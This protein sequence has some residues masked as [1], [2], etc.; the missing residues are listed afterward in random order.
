MK[1]F[2]VD[3]TKYSLMKINHAS[4]GPTHNVALKLN[5]IFIVARIVYTIPGFGFFYGVCPQNSVC[6][7]TSETDTDWG[8]HYSCHV[9]DT[10][11]GPHSAL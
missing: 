8:I 4:M 7:N 5:I 2:G 10:G 9:G 3:V 1:N 11:A 6:S